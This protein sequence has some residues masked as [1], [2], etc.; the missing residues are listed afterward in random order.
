MEV[1]G[2]AQFDTKGSAIRKKRS[3]IS[4]RPKDSQTFTDNHDYSS[5]SPSPPSDD[6]NKGSSYK[7]ADNSRRKEFNLNQSVSRVF[8]ATRTESKNAICNSNSG[9]S[10]INNKR[11]SEG[12]LAPANWRSASNLKECMDVESTTAN[13]YSGRN[14]G[15]WSSE[16]SG[17]S[18]DALGNE[19]K[20]K[21]VKRKVGGVARTINPNS[22]TN[23]VSSTEN[24]D[25]QTLPGQGRNLVFRGI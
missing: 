7:N 8:P 4:R 17:V 14:G 15:S 3:H 12:V 13:M 5:L 18:L 22:T 10:V 16:Q 21:N 6:G 24:L 25:S 23:G 11:F 20:V 2:L 9:K 19:S 1:L